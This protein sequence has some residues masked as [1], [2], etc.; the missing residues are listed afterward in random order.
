MQTSLSNPLLC[1][2]FVLGAI[3]L[4]GCVAPTP[5]L[6][7]AERAATVEAI[8][9]RVVEI[10]A[11]QTAVQPITQAAPA[12][13]PIAESSSRAVTPEQAALLA[14]LRPQ[15]AAPEL[16]NEVW[17]NSEP[18]KLADLRGQVVIVEFWTY[19]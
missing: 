10:R 13:A 16:L 19:G 2:L 1:L 5:A 8:Q 14:K 15:G 4:T 17:L 11:T 12:P 18:L 6:D 9:T 7:E 3:A